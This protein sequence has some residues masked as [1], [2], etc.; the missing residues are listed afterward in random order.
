MRDEE[1]V[2]EV[3]VAHRA[4]DRGR[5]REHERRRQRLP[6]RGDDLLVEVGQR[7]DEPD[8][9]LGDERRERPDVARVVDAGDERHAVGVIEGGRKRV[10]VGGDGRRARTSEGAH[11]VDAL[12]RAGEEHGGHPDAGE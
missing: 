12:S 11:D 3:L 6:V 2:R 9:V 8:V 7:D 4:T 5:R 1:L 10:E